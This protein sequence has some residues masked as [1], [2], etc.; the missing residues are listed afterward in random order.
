M[1]GTRSGRDARVRRYPAQMLYFS[2]Q[3][4]PFT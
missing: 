4:H 3:V 1:F 2:V